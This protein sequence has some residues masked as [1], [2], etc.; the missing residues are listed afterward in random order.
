MTASRPRRVFH[1]ADRAQWEQAVP[2]GEYRWS[3]RGA[4]LE[5]V[6]FI[7]CSA[8]PGQVREVAESF[9]RDYDASLV[10]L[11]IDADAAG[12]GGVEVRME[13]GGGGELF[14]HLYGALR[15]DW[16]VAVYPARFGD[17]G[18]EWGER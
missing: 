18:F 13:D 5:E 3:T 17:R 6:G 12:R 10:V 7:H 15:T 11:E 4:R 1:I 2:T 8:T 14:P 16:V 9:Y